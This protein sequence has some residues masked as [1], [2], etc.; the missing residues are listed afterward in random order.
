MGRARLY[1]IHCLD[2]L[3]KKNEIVTGFRLDMDD[4]Y[5]SMLIFYFVLISEEGCDARGLDFAEDNQDA[6][7]NQPS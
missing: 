3:M 5:I 7:Q 2:E 4:E 1:M 6:V